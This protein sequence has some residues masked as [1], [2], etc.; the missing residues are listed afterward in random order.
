MKV[1]NFVRNRVRRQESAD[2]RRAVR[3]N[4]TTEQQIAL[5]ANRP[6]QSAKELARLTRSL[7]I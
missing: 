4:R 7:E 6:G 2:I 1:R 3:K 5:I